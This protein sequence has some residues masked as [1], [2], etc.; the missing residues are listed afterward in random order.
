MSNRDELVDEI[1]GH[2]I[3]SGYYSTNVGINEAREIADSLLQ[4]GYRKP[5]TITT[6]DEL[7]ALPFE[8]VLR[9]FDGHVLER[10]GQPSENL[11][12]TVMVTSYIPRRDISL[13]ATV[14]FDPEAAL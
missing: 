12:A 4:A 5:R 14:L 7:D 6:L 11:W 13:P 8:A 9:D 3:G 1:A 2:P 10:W